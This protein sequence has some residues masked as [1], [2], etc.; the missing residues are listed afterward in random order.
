MYGY[1]ACNQDW[2]SSVDSTDLM[3]EKMLSGARRKQY[4][5]GILH[6]F[7]QEVQV[8]QLTPEGLLRGDKEDLLQIRKLRKQP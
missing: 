7:H 8:E 5:L 1:P 2:I 4:L 3:T 6:L